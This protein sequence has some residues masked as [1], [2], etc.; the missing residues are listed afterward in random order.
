MAR[1]RASELTINLPFGI[2]R[3]TLVPD[4]AQERAA[5][6]LYVELMTR[7]AVQPLSAKEGLLREA[8]TSLY[9]LFGQTRNILREAGPKVAQGANPFGLIAIEVLN[10]GLRPFTSKWH[11]RLQTYEETR[12]KDKSPHDH[13]QA[14]GEEGVHMRTEL[15]ALQK[16]LLEYAKALAKIAGVDHDKLIPDSTKS[17][18]KKQSD[19]GK[20]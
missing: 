15:E 11:P 5:W 14:W 12:P 16:D 4:E 9:S 20:K 18:D 8:L 6:S 7:I 2:G 1:S 13:E 3:L 19:S 10:K 17:A